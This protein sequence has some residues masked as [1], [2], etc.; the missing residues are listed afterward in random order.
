VVWPGRLSRHRVHGR[1]I[2]VDAAHNAEAAHALAA[3]LATVPDRH[4]LLFSCLDDKPVEAMARV[5][6]PRVGDVAI[7]A[8][9]DPRAMGVDRMASA[10]PVARVAENPLSA[11]SM[12]PDPV[13]AAGSLRLVGALLEEAE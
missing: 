7:V 12:L 3:H 5:L 1:Q 13:L 9:D 4:N 2:L 10:F 6:L 8:V 11:L